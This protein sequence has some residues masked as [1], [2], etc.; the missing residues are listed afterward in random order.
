MRLGSNDLVLTGK[1]NLL[2]L[3]ALCRVRGV[4]AGVDDGHEQ[5]AGE[6]RDLVS[7]SAREVDIVNGDRLAQIGERINRGEFCLLRDTNKCRNPEEGG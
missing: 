5:R 4:A 6:R 2:R 1:P 7:P 3:M